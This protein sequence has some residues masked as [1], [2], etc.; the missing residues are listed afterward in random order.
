MKYIKKYLTLFLLS[1]FL[2]F[3]AIF[4]WFEGGTI[5]YYWDSLLPFSEKYAFAFFN[6][7]SSWVF[8]GSSGSGLSWV[9]YTIPLAILNKYFGLSIAQ[10]VIYFILISLSIINF[11]L[12]LN[13]FLSTLFKASNKLAVFF[14]SFIFSVM[15]SLNLYT[16]Y[17]A[18]FMFNPGAYIIAFLPLNFLAL[19]HIF[20]LDK[21][22]AGKV[23][24][25]IM[26][27][28]SLFLMSPGFTTYIFFLQY[29]SWLFLYLAFYLF[30]NRYNFQQHLKKIFLFSVLFL[31]LNSWWF[32][33]SL[34]NFQSSY[35]SARFT[36]DKT[37]YFEANSKNGNLLN[38]LRIVGG[39]MMNN[40]QFGWF[41][42]YIN[43]TPF[44]FILFFLPFLL[45]FLLVK[46]NQISKKRTLYFFFTIFLTSLFLIKQA[47]PPLAYLTKW[48]FQYIPFF[49]AFRDGYH[50]AGL[51]Y[52]FA[53]FVLSGLGFYLLFDF[54]K[55]KKRK[56][57]IYL[58]FLTVFLLAVSVTG[59][60]F[61]FS[62][63]NTQKVV[64]KYKDN[65]YA[66]S[67]KTK[68][69]QEYYDLKKILEARCRGRATIVIP[70]ATAITNAY[71]SKYGTSYIGQDVLS[72]LVNCSLI[73]TRV[74]ENDPDAF[75]I[76]P[77]LLL[78]GGELDAF[79][80]FL[81]QNKI[82]LI[83]VRK[84]NIPYHYTTWVYLDS[85]FLIK[86]LDTRNGFEKIYQNDFFSLYGLRSLDNDMTFGFSLTNQPVY[87]NSQLTKGEEYI[88]LSKSLP[89]DSNSLLINKNVD[90]KKYKQNISR[91]IVF[92]NC[93]GCTI[94]SEKALLNFEE[95]DSII[96]KTKDF[97]RPYL[98]PESKKE[99]M[100][101]KISLML[102]D[103]NKQFKKMVE[104][105][106]DN[107]YEE[108]EA[109]LDKYFLAL[110]DIMEV[111]KNYNSS[112]FNQNQ[113]IIEARNFIYAQRN[114][115]LKFTSNKNSDIKRPVN[116]LV[117][118]INNNLEFINS[119]VWLA[120]FDKNL[121][122]VRVDI[123]E[124]SLYECKAEIFAEGI[125]IKKSSVDDNFK[126][127]LDGKVL[128]DRRSYPVTIEYDPDT[129]KVEE[130]DLLKLSNQIDLG[131]LKNGKYAFSF[132]LGNLKEPLTIAITKKPIYFE[133][134]T[135][136]F[137]SEL[138][139]KIVYL[140]F[141]EEE[142]LQGTFKGKFNADSYEENQ[143]YYLY[144]ILGEGND[145]KQFKISNLL[146][147]REPSE[148][149][150]FFYCFSGN[151]FPMSNGEISVK[152]INEMKYEV[153]LE[154]KVENNFLTFN[155]S[156]NDFW[157]AFDEEGKKLKHLKNG[158]ANAWDL[159]DMK[160]DK[161][162]IVFSKQ[163]IIIKNIVISLLLFT[164]LFVVFLKIIKNDK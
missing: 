106:E 107:R 34:L 155:Q 13:Y 90:F 104:T 39:Q 63:D 52:I 32:F 120:D 2:S 35:E 62:Y 162:T 121:Y 68:I 122:R 111:L 11:Y 149:E 73:N 55:S 158:Y 46:S 6:N 117:S 24:W 131:S 96:K 64:F 42:F 18:Y 141:I 151:K 20:P 130:I 93:V 79:E 128:L 10:G 92:G 89:I 44:S 27:F 113:K 23:F 82:S 125:K 152:K 28:I 85:L 157:V 135:K 43:K 163:D 146:I 78:Q 147:K 127:T 49:D 126:L 91:Y 103:S 156:Y 5:L 65:S 16:F 115:L 22:E 148:N 21:R 60:F 124:K 118:A 95:R 101:V 7:W 102:L 99:N 4:K 29:S 153:S 40:N 51:F 77:Y 38:A 12:F 57:P 98:K 47:N 80:N 145:A 112:F 164:G 74:G 59:P 129:F 87:V 94:I 69:P 26:F 138:K 144:L 116:F 110:S 134:K 81:R 37:A 137:S 97:L 123:P 19:L 50:K 154:K 132:N 25:S 84:D 72:K 150:V 136:N 67:A 66:F 119:K 1:S 143:K 83:L 161:V 17:Y 41:P 14:V 33:P 36:V 109:S 3:L 159:S 45:I 75:S 142:D 30:V 139:D 100:E 56:I 114:Y 160:G 31:L 108:F 76:A 86:Q 133:N 9:L 15:Y 53:Y 140:A 48:A 105:I 71:W 70:R 61:I 8:P 88:A 58:L 54:F